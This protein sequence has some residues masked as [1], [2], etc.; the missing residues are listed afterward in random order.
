MSLRSFKLL[1]SL[2]L[3]AAMLP[4]QSFAEDAVT[5][6]LHGQYRPRYEAGSKAALGS[7]HWDHAVSQRARI[8]LGLVW[9]DW[10]VQLDPQHVLTWG[11]SRGA[12]PN[13]NSLSGV[14]GT[15]DFHQ[16][17]VQN[18]FGNGGML[19]I[20]RQAMAFDGQQILGGVD[21]TQQG[22]K[23]DAIR[24]SYAPKDADYDFDVFGALIA[25]AGAKTTVG[26]AKKPDDVMFGLHGS[27]K[28]SKLKL[29]TLIVG[30]YSKKRQTG[31]QDYLRFTPGLEVNGNFSGVIVGASA[32][33]Q[34]GSAKTESY[35]AYMVTGRLGYAHKK[36][37]KAVAGIDYLSGDGNKAD[38]KKKAFDTLW[39]T[40]HKFYGHMDY[41][42]APPA[43]TAQLGLN[44]LHLD[45]STG[46]IPKVTTV[47]NIH[48]FL[49]TQSSAGGNSDLGI[50][51]DLKLVH[52][53][54]SKVK[55][56]GGY[57]F[58][59]AGDAMKD[60]GRA[61]AAGDLSHWTWLQLDV[62]L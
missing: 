4:V 15:F 25:E 29:A 8:K 62:N 45:L 19:R 11:T 40:N 22:R 13:L 50:E 46:L 23:F 55:L 16:A 26:V 56:V 60:I 3:L 32:Y 12:V 7:S 27:Y 2:L 21:W 9:G 20:G 37:I 5:L 54:N 34:F 44:D 28:V 6:D 38:T 43:H 24:M 39:A 18:K 17:Y 58:F 48:Y 47:L 14:S 52:A 57:S 33:G 59:L 42:L 35:K 61:T 36:T 31:V 51:P 30:E 10:R 53:I 1:S 41:F 49:T